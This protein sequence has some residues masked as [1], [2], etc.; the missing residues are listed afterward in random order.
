MFQQ[1]LKLKL[2]WHA[3]WHRDN[4]TCISTYRLEKKIDHM[5]SGITGRGKGDR[6]PPETSDQEISADLPGKKRQGKKG[7]GVKI[8]KK[9]RKI[10][11]GKLG[12]WK[13]ENGRLK[14][15][16]MR[17]GPF[18]FFSSRREKIRKNYFAPSEKFSCYAPDH[19]HY[20]VGKR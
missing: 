9:R 12:R 18:F 16:K 7:K 15:Y 3:C 19:S 8:E 14:S 13:I 6:V 11:K 2:C 1:I 5:A 4:I 10:V 17:R 20:K